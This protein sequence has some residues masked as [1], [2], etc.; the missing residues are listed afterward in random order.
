MK[1]NTADE[2]RS[3]RSNVLLRA[4]IDFGSAHIAVRVSNLSRHGV[5]AMAKNLPPEGA[6]VVFRYK[7]L[8]IP[9]WIAWV[10]SGCAGVQF[11]DSTKL[12]GIGRDDAFRDF[13]ITKDTRALDFRRPGFRGNQL[14]AEERAIIKDWAASRHA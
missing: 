13:A 2:R 10:R 9:S 5:L 8:A 7:T 12:D 4:T 1:I 6:E 14:T 3:P 11:A